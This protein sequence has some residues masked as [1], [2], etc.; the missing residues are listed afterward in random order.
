VKTVSQGILNKKTP[1]LSLRNCDRLA[2]PKQP[3]KSRRGRRDLQEGEKGERGERAGTTEPT[4]EQKT[5]APPREL[6]NQKNR[7]DISARSNGLKLC[8]IRGEG[9]VGGGAIRRH[10]GD[11]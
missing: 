7:A 6:Q 4:R 10:M 11:Y 1:V 2:P 9:E 3:R 5:S 8:H